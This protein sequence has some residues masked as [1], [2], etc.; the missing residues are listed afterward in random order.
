MDKLVEEGLADPQRLGIGGWSYGGMNTNY[1]IA[2]DTRFVAA[3]SGAS[4]SNMI[5]G[6][7][8]DQYI[9]QYE[10]ELGLPWE[11]IGYYLK[12]SYPFFHAD[13]IKTPTLFLC[14][15]KD[16]NVPLIN[17]EQ[18]YQA[19]RSLHVPTQLV[20]YP[21]QYHGLSKPSYI[22]DRLERMIDWYGRYMGLENVVS[23]N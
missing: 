12:S 14:G 13:R 4:I 18:M 16:F 7:G 10:G 19:L 3:V 1:A 21:G 6:Y 11:S 9:R 15:E 20:I 8:T 17:S 5:T 2:T 23:E 22:Q